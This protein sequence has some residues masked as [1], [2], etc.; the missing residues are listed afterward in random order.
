MIILGVDGPE[1]FP[2]CWACAHSVQTCVWTCRLQLRLSLSLSCKGNRSCLLEIS[3][4]SPVNCS[5]HCQYT[6]MFRYPFLRVLSL[7][8]VTGRLD[9]RPA[10][11][12]G[13]PARASDTWKSRV[14]PQA[15]GIQTSSSVRVE[16]G[17]AR[18]ETGL[19]ERFQNVL[20]RVRGFMN[21]LVVWIEAPRLR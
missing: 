19:N 13:S 15:V 18:S 2:S 3:L 14:S 17:P 4:P 6:T 20:N 11:R 9:G 21:V 12:D 7:A 5:C 10:R 16:N 8:E 1:T